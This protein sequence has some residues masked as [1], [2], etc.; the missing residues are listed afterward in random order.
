MAIGSSLEELYRT[1]L[2]RLP[3][4]QSRPAIQL[5]EWCLQHGLTHQAAELLI[6]ASQQPH[7]AV[8]LKGVQL[9]LQ[10]EILRKRPGHVTTEKSQ[11]LA[12]QDV[13]P[14]PIS[15]SPAAMQQFTTKIQPLLL[16][17]CS[18]AGCHGRGTVS[19]FELSRPPGGSP[20]T[21]GLTQANAARTAGYINFAS[22][23]NSRLLHMAGQAHGK[24][25]RA[26]LNNSQQRRLAEW[27]R[28][29]A[30]QSPSTNS[31][32]VA[33]VS[34]TA[35]PRSGHR[36]TAPLLDSPPDRESTADR[37]QPLQPAAENPFDP[38]AYNELY[39][40]PRQPQ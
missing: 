25:S 12:I 26:A 36:P 7:D 27:V 23:E 37:S 39:A 3:H 17:R 18:N 40:A 28:S 32:S 16:N 4:N 31:A 30:G 38:A 34:Q 5:A 15:L 8:K 19:T 11:P 13:D 20:F 35:N 24:A 6:S 9:R 21:H 29:V 33:A 1:Q 10:Q 2:Q 14:A 22:P